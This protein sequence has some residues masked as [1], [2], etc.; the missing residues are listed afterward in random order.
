[1]VSK[2]RGQFYLLGG[3]HRTV[4]AEIRRALKPEG[5]AVFN[6]AS[7]RSG[8]LGT[9]YEALFTTIRVVFPQAA[10]FS[11]NPAEPS[12]AQNIIVVVT[13]GQPLPEDDLH[14]FESSRVRDVPARGLLLTD[15]FA[16]T[17]YLGLALARELYP[18]QR[19]F[20]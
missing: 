16:P 20:Q 19:P 12:E 10:V 1:M 11:T 8:K 14:S 13:G 18:K 6:I 4:F 3:R 15:D 2:R 5:I 17:E 9:V 7:A